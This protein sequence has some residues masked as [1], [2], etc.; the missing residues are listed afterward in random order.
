MSFVHFKFKSGV[1]YD[2]VTFDGVAITLADLK[3]AIMAKKK[4]GQTAGFDLQ[5]TNSQTKEGKFYLFI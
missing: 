3:K 5:V 4:G 1:D 2:K